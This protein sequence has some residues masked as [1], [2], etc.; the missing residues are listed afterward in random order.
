[1]LYAFLLVDRHFIRDGWEP[2]ASGCQG[3]IKSAR[4]THTERRE[5]AGSRVSMKQQCVCVF[6]YIHSGVRVSGKH[7]CEVVEYST[8]SMSCT[9]TACPVHAKIAVEDPT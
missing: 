3:G 7:A 1:M 9:R 2:V 4:E 5:S 6:T 8:H